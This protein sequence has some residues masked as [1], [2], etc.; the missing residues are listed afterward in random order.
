NAPAKTRQREGFAEFFRVYTL[1][2]D[3]ARNKWPALTADVET[4]LRGA[5]PAILDGLNSLAARFSA[6]LQ[7]PSSRLI[8]SMVVD[9]R[10][11]QGIN[12]A[13]K[14]LKDL[15][16]KSWFEEYT[17]RAV[18]YSVNRFAPLNSVVNQL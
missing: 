18:D 1:T 10:R 6:W 15:G 5:D 13:V 16:F 11:D 2:P 7:L 17:R 3:Y 14:E 8:R 12:A 4:T 9:G